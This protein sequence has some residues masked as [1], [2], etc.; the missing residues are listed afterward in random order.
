MYNCHGKNSADLCGCKRLTIA[1]CEQK[2]LSL[3]PLIIGGVVNG[4]SLPRSWTCLFQGPS[5]VVDL[6]PYNKVIPDDLNLLVPTAGHRL[7]P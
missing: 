5:G 1:W 6:K 7:Q 4:C 3:G 2:T